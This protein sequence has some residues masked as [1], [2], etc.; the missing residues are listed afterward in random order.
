MKEIGKETG[1]L[2]N[3]VAGKAQMP[4]VH[5]FLKYFVE[6]PLFVK[7]MMEYA[8]YNR[9]IER[10]SGGKQRVTRLDDIETLDSKKRSNA[11]SRMYSQI[12]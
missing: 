12:T 11:N 7:L 1:K 8:A 2:M 5:K 3:N 10:V 4:E 6:N 9:N